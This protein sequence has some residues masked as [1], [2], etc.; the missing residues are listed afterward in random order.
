MFLKKRV[1]N[2]QGLIML[3]NNETY[4]TSYPN[5]FGFYDLNETKI[6]NKC[7]LNEKNETFS[8]RE[9]K[10]KFKAFDSPNQSYTI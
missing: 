7:K 1:L 4:K 10:N 2:L 3:W 8:F 6:L 5:P 9:N